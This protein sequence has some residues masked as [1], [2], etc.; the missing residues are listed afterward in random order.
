MDASERRYR[1]AFTR[2]Q[3]ARLEKEFSKENYLSRPRRCELA[4]KLN[5]PELT[6]KIWFQ[7]RRMKDKR[8]R[9]T[10]AWPYT[11][12]YADPTYAASLLHSANAI[13]VPYG[14]ASAMQPQV[15]AMA[16]S[17]YYPYYAPY[18]LPTIHQQPMAGY[19]P[20]MMS[21]YMSHPYSAMPQPQQQPLHLYTALAEQSPHSTSSVSPIGS[22]SSSIFNL[23]AAASVATTEPAPA[24]RGVKRSSPTSSADKCK[25]FKPYN[26]DE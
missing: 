10:V 14:Y 23:N 13:T 5:L 8:Q 21:S 15:P 20:S 25:I 19:H 4:A 16:A 9:V 7:N 17:H 26:F 12:V 2:E 1:T 24:P 6:I 11:A 22:D 3:L 18:S